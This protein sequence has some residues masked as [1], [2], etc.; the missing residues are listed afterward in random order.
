MTVPHHPIEV[1]TRNVCELSRANK[2]QTLMLSEL[3]EILRKLATG[4]CWVTSKEEVIH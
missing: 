1:G 2:L 4:S 3:K